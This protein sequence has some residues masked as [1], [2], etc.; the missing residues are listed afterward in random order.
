MRQLCHGRHY[1]MDNTIS[2]VRL[3]Y[4]AWYPRPQLC[5]GRHHTLH[6]EKVDTRLLRCMTWRTLHTLLCSCLGWQALQLRRHIGT[7]PRLCACG[8][9]VRA[10]RTCPGGAACE[11]A[12]ASS[13]GWPGSGHV[14]C[15]LP[16]S[17]M[18]LHAVCRACAAGQGSGAELQCTAQWCTWLACSLVSHTVPVNKQDP[19]QQTQSLCMSSQ[20]HGSR[21]QGAGCCNATHLRRS[22]LLLAIERI[23]VG[24]SAHTMAWRHIIPE[25]RQRA[26]A[27]SWTHPQSMPPTFCSCC[28]GCWSSTM[29]SVPD[30]LY[31]SLLF[32]KYQQASA[33][34]DAATSATCSTSIYNNW[35]VCHPVAS[36][37]VMRGWCCST[38]CRCCCSART[39]LLRRSVTNVKS[40]PSSR[41]P[42]Q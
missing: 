13:F 23:S 22:G 27:G 15:A 6:Y 24:N 36:Y 34:G 12:A 7:W 4:M 18:L 26:L 25:N 38:C 17:D 31:C 2:A 39:F 11:R 28:E 20:H 41:N 21:V 9:A 10:Q 37:A 14:N 35:K 29:V 5:H 16:P 40:C 1:T 19:A 3:L 42:L 30:I 33:A 32:G 8:L